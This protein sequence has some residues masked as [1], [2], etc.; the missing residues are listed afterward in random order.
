MR[1][2]I[3]SCLGVKKSR[4]LLSRDRK[5]ALPHASGRSHECERGTHE[6]VRY[7][8]SLLLLA[9]VCEGAIVLDRMAVIVGNHVIKT[10]D[11]D[12]DL[13]LTEFMN[14][15]PLNL[16]SEAK[17]RSAERLI[18]QEI[19]RMEIVTGGYRRPSEAEADAF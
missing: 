13:R 2:L 5:G 3:P 10:S 14:R 8:V 9:S 16:G 18:D 6:C 19:I 7:V 17:R 12:R 15:E 1:Y 4:N 11:I